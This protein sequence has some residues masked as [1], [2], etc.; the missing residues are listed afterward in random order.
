MG[1]GETL[2]LVLDSTSKTRATTEVVALFFSSH[3]FFLNMT[4]SPN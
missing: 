4:G 2:D 3:F 1:V